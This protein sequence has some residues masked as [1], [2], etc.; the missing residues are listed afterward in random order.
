MKAIIK[1]VEFNKEF[2][3]QHGTLYGFT[4]TYDDKKAFY[5][6]KSKDQKKFI[7][8]QEAEFTEETITKDGKKY[9]IIKPVYNRGQSNYGKALSREQSKY[10]GFADSYVKD[11]LVGGIILPEIDGTGAEEHNDIVMITWKKRAFEIFEHMVQLDKT[12]QS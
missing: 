4:I 7:K 6:S 3:S 2:E 12:L 11:L 1:S 9:L 8:G 5:K 10:S